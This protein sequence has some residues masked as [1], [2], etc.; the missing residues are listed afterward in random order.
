MQYTQQQ[1]SDISGIHVDTLRKIENGKVTPVQETLDILSIAFKKDLNTLLLEFRLND[2]SSFKNIKKELESKLDKNEY[3]TLPVELQKLKNLL[4]KE[5]NTY[6]INL[7]KQLILL[8]ESVLLSKNDSGLKKALNK[9]I[10][11]IKTTTPKFS[12]D[13]YKR[14]VYSSMELRI[15]MNIA[16]LINKIESAEESLKV[17]KFCIEKVELNDPLYLK[18]CYNLSYTYHRLD[19]HKN[20]LRYADFGIKYCNKHREFNG[21]NLLYFRKGIAEYFLKKDTYMSSLKKSIF[22]CE[23]LQQYKLKDLLISNCKS[24]YNLNIS[25]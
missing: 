11:A 12:L 18:I 15:L 5:S 22:L 2:Y 4:N 1:V 9:C 24:M 6:F 13:N 23:I 14:F 17:M 16:L 10:I 21:L 25:H 7:I 20:A 19:L 3:Q 8:L